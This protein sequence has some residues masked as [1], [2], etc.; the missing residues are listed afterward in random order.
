MHTALSGPLR[1]P[2]YAREDN[3]QHTRGLKVN[4]SRGQTKATKRKCNLS[5]LHDMT[6]KNL[7]KEHTTVETRLNK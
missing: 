5:R 1:K 6:P 4:N 7:R 3:F 2:A